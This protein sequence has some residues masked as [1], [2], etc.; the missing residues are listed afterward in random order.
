MTRNKKNKLYAMTIALLTALVC[1]LGVSESAQAGR[2]GHYIDGKYYFYFG[3]YTVGNLE[4]KNPADPINVVFY[5]PNGEY[6]ENEIVTDIDKVIPDYE[7]KIADSNQYLMFTTASGRHSNIAYREVDR[8]MATQP[9]LVNRDHI[10][11]W[12]DDTAAALLG[13]RTGIWVVAG[14]HH[15][16]FDFGAHNHRVD[17]DWDVSRRK[18]VSQMIHG[19]D[20]GRCADARWKRHPLARGWFGDRSRRQYYHHNSGI[21][22]RVTK[23]TRQYGCRGA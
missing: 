7:G 8:A 19:N 18:F 10:R 4:N 13:R 22:A 23:Q 21:L 16:H 14:A 11:L 1:T 6:G 17:I 9:A 5:S 2:L 12:G 15:D 3:G 20:H